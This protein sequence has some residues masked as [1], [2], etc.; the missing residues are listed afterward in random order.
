[1]AECEGGLMIDL[2]Q[3]EVKATVFETLKVRKRLIKLN[4]TLSFVAVANDGF[5]DDRY[6]ETL[7][8]YQTLHEEYNEV[9]QKVR[10]LNPQIEVDFTVSLIPVVDQIH[11]QNYT[12]PHGET[13]LK[14]LEQLENV[15]QN[16]VLDL[17]VQC[18]E[19]VEYIIS[20]R[21]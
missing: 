5:D 17:D 12:N 16:L 2:N 9:I 10:A 13:I 1:M 19:R 3:A 14:V 15:T 18:Q 4:Q 6:K 7:N 8:A 20:K 11:S 21:Q